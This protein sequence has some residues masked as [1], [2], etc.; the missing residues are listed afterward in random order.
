MRGFIIRISLLNS[1]AIGAILLGSGF[2]ASAQTQPDFKNKT[3]RI[4][5]GT[6][7]GGGVD[8]YSRLIVSF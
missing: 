6:S 4:I 8:L 5:V 1:W 3:V 7:T 2:Q